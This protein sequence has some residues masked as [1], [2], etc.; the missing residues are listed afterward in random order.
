MWMLGNSSDSDT[1][2][3]IPRHCLRRSRLR[4]LVPGSQQRR[5]AERKQ[6][7]NPQP[8]QMEREARRA[9]KAMMRWV[10]TCNTQHT[11]AAARKH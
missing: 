5:K 3:L 6:L 1:A 11:H 9:T 7:Q 2:L 4:T 8:R 10:S